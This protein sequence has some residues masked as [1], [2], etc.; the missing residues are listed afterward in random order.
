M[1]ENFEAIKQAIAEQRVR[2]AIVK[3][4]ARQLLIWPTADQK[5]WA[6][7]GL[8]WFSRGLGAL[9]I[10]SSL[11]AAYAWVTWELMQMIFS[12]TISLVSL[13]YL[14]RIAAHHTQD[15]ALSDEAFFHAGRESGLIELEP[16]T[17]RAE[18]RGYS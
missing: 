12:C 1:Q 17:G 5:Q 2:L 18:S 15:K 13:R 6:P 4:K 16:V 10:G 8:Q 14:D 7:S 3:P 9:F 11:T